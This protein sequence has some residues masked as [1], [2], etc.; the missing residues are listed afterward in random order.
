MTAK[1]FTRALVALALPAA[2]AAQAAPRPAP[3]AAPAAVD[4]APSGRRS[5]VQFL[6]FGVVHSAQV[7]TAAATVTDESAS[8]AGL[9][10]LLSPRSGGIA[11]AGRLLSSGLGLKYTDASVLLGGRIFAL[12]LGY[13]MRTGHD[14]VGLEP[15]DSTYSF[16]RG[17]FRSRANLGNTGFTV[18]LKA[19]YYV[20]I[21]SDQDPGPETEGWE[22]ETNLYWSWARFPLTAMMGYR[23]ER[24]RVWGVEQEVSSLVIGGGVALGRR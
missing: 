17:G 13:V 5:P 14:P 19:G 12:D 21:P 9:E 2:L 15:F 10:F 7:R 1:T 3:A 22:G 4:S 8:L 18:G 24:F 23:I 16:A 6:L 11:I 20:G